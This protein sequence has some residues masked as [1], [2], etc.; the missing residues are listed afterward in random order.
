MPR[1][2]IL[3]LVV[4]SDVC[5]AQ[6]CAEWLDCTYGHGWKTPQEKKAVVEKE[7]WL[8]HL[9]HSQQTTNASLKD[10]RDT[11]GR[12]FWKHVR[13]SPPCSVF[14]THDNARD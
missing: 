1:H 11:L 6:F 7:V 4:G 9:Y 2:S 14:I 8:S 3:K 12:E 13:I 10:P 5:A